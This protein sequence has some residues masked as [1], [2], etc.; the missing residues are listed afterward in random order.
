MI[1]ICCP[2]GCNLTINGTTLEDLVVTGNRCPRGAEYAKEELFAPKRTVTAV[3]RTDSD[4]FPYIP[5]KTDKPL[6]KQL[7]PELLKAINSLR[8][9]LPVQSGQT[10]IENFCNTE[11]NVVVTRSVN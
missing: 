5:V 7:I 4:A 11:V 10:V 9:S 3:V 6:A 2:I 1:C 8:I